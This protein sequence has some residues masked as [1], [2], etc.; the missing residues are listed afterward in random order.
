MT[1]AQTAKSSVRRGS[2]I[3]I[4]APSGSGKSTLVRRLLDSVPGLVFSISYTTRPPRPGEK[5]K[6]DYFFV[7]T[8]RFKRMVAA[9]E[10]VE[11]ADVFGNFYGTSWK[12]LRAAQAAGKDVLLD[13][14]VQGHQQVRRRLP[15]VASVFILPP[16][17]REL[18]RRL[19]HRHSD[20]PQVIARRLK[21]ARK[22]IPHWREYDYLVVNDRLPRA[23]RALRVVLEAA[24]LR[25]L[26]QQERAKKI[27][28]TFGGKIG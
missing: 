27:L 18:A 23:T 17:F 11:W 10:F 7:S 2:I 9:G 1:L 4:S 12:Q 22:E 14:D 24:S 21:D 15:E 16:S 3:V 19:R 25:R 13:I 26:I 8:A 20:E 6:K 5:N 28:K